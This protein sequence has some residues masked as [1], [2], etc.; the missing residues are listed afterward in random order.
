[1]GTD[2]ALWRL[3]PIAPQAA[4]DGQGGVLSTVFIVLGVLV[5]LLLI[6]FAVTL[7]R[8][9]GRQLDEWGNPLS[10]AKPGPPDAQAAQPAPPPDDEPPTPPA[11]PTTP[12]GRT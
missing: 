12:G 9:P 10:Q 7:A 6:G 2:F 8:R 3:T 1:M 5:V 11:P 4:D